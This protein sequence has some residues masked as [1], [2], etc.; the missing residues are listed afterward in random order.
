MQE[1]AFELLKELLLYQSAGAY[2]SLDRAVELA[3]ANYC[4][5]SGEPAEKIINLINAAKTIAWR[6]PKMVEEFPERQ[7]QYETLI[8][9]LK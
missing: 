2:E 8:D 7:A 1:V 9:T 4:W 5:V 6:D 3:I